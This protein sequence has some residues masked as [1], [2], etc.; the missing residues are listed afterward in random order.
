ML[1][2][3]EA[4]ENDDVVILMRGEDDGWRKERQAKGVAAAK[5]KGVRFGRPKTPVP[6]GFDDYAR[7]YEEGKMTRK[8]IMEQTGCG[9]TT[10]YNLLKEYRAKVSMQR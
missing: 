2:L 3:M 6:E 4:A 1:E 7:L 10:F 5:A 8:E 9:Q